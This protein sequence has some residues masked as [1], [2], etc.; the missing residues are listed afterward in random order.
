L[1]VT[2]TIY[3]TGELTGEPEGKSAISLTQAVVGLTSGFNGL[4]VPVGTKLIVV[5]P[6]TDNTATLTVK[7]VTGDTG[8]K[9]LMTEPTIL[10]WGGSPG[11]TLGITA[12]AVVTTLK[13]LYI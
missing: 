13:V 8:F 6:P 4:S 11:D 3:A 5:I 7:G 2:G 10:T 9:I 1:A 12:S